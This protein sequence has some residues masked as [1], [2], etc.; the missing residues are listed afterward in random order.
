[1]LGYIKQECHSPTCAGAERL[2]QRM[3]NIGDVVVFGC[4]HCAKRPSAADTEDDELGGR[5]NFEG[6]ARTGFVAVP[7]DEVEQYDDT[8]RPDANP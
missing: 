4:T 5:V 6:M 2:F 1:M 3:Y 7:K 8:G